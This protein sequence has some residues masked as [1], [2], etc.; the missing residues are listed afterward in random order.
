MVSD[1]KEERWVLCCFKVLV[2]F[3]VFWFKVLIWLDKILMLFMV[4]V[5]KIFFD[6]EL[7]KGNKVCVWC[8]LFVILVWWIMLWIDLIV[9]LNCKRVFLCKLWIKLVKLLSSKYEVILWVVLSE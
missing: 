1:I 7:I 2:N 3:F 5:L 4:V 8:W 9:L 6:K